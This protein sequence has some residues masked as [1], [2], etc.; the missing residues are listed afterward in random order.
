MAE[1]DMSAPG[2]TQQPLL[3]EEE[4]RPLVESALPV[5]VSHA[6]SVDDLRMLLDALGIDA[7]Q[8]TLTFEVGATDLVDSVA[9]VQRR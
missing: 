9:S 7:E 8:R 6:D 2:N 4:Y 3:L 5:I 1:V